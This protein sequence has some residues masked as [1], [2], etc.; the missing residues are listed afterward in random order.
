MLAFCVVCLWLIKC[1]YNDQSYNIYLQIAQIFNKVGVKF[2]DETF[3]EAWNLA[4]M[5]HP[6]GDVCVKSFRNALCELQAL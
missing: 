4:S 6:T 1:Q 2:S 5:K 3:D